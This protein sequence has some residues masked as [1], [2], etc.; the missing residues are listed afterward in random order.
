MEEPLGFIK[1]MQFY[2]VSCGELFIN[3]L[4]VVPFLSLH[5]QPYTS[6][7]SSASGLCHLPVFM[8]TNLSK[9]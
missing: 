7:V 3:V 1:G 2:L 5:Q 8:V 6:K 9:F 4:V